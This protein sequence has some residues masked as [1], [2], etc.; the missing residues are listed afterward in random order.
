MVVQ[1]LALIQV[2]GIA[3]MAQRLLRDWRV[4]RREIGAASAP[5]GPAGS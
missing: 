4:V 1:I 5:G 2:A 3:F